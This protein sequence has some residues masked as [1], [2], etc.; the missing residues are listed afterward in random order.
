MGILIDMKYLLKLCRSAYNLKRFKPGQ[1]VLFV[2]MPAT[3]YGGGQQYLYRLLEAMKR[4]E[5][6][7]VFA[8]PAFKNSDIFLK[9]ISS[10]GATGLSFEA[11]SNGYKIFFQWLTIVLFFAPSFIHIN[12]YHHGTRSVLAMVPVLKALL[13]CKVC[14]TQHLSLFSENSHS[15]ITKAKKIS[16]RILSLSN[17]RWWMRDY[18]E[19]KLLLRFADKIIFVDDTHKK[20]YQSLLGLRDQKV[21]TI[22]NGVDTHKFRPGIANSEK[23]IKVRKSLGIGEDDFLIIGIGN[24]IPQKRFD[25]FIHVIARL[26]RQGYPAKGLVAGEG[27]LL[28]DLQKVE[29]G[30]GCFMSLFFAGHRTDI[31]LLLNISD[32]FLMTSDDEGLPYALL[33]AKACGLPSVATSAGGI[34]EVIQDGIDGYIVPTED[35]GGL[36]SSVKTII[37]DPQKYR[38]MGKLAREDIMKRFSLKK[39]QDKTI[40]VFQSL[41]LR[42]E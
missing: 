3:A 12:G 13:R 16:L 22:I 37:D 5:L 19:K 17:Y 39:M 9:E 27:S 10:R 34:R 38:K 26:I 29:Q 28:S 41:G 25:I 11:L 23:R 30:E 8:F 42:L 31:P 33:E 24:L 40:E 14:V 36:V 21:K 4:N 18:Y 7:I 15:F 32:L 35:I 2:C 1:R 20:L 6:N